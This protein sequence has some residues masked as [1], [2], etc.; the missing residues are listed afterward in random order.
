MTERLRSEGAIPQPEQSARPAEAPPTEFQLFMRKVLDLPDYRTEGPAAKTME[1]LGERIK[2]DPLQT[3]TELDAFLRGR[4]TGGFADWSVRFITNTAIGAAATGVDVLDFP[5]KAL[6]KMLPIGPFGDA[7][8]AGIEYTT[9]TILSAGTNKLAELT[10]GVKGIRYASPLSETISTFANTI[11]GVHDVV[12]GVNMESALRRLESVPILGAVLE[13][14]HVAGD[15]M[16]N[17]AIET[18]QGKWLW[19]LLIVMSKG[20]NKKP[21]AKNSASTP[22]TSTPTAAKN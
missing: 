3:I 1:E 13:Q 4:K 11:P 9:D 22:S 16:I 10:T 18:Q 6:V 19:G 7:I 20:Y 2:A 8:G 21:E 14:G 5:A 15:R 12:N 17:Q